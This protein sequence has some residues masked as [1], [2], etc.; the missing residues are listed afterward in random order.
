MGENGGMG[1]FLVMERP[2]FYPIMGSL[3]AVVILTFILWQMQRHVAA[4]ANR[5]GGLRMG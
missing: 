1:F 4:S 5:G 2:V 3:D